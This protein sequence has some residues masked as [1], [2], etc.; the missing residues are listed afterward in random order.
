MVLLN[1][2]KLAKFRGLYP[3]SLFAFLSQ[4]GQN[5]LIKLMIKK[6]RLS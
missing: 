1:K 3:L 2:T 5:D 6:C 4:K